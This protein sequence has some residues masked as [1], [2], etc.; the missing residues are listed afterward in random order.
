MNR[1]IT[2]F[3]RIVAAAP[4]LAFVLVATPLSAVKNRAPIRSPG[5]RFALPALFLGILLAAIPVAATAQPIGDCWECVASPFPLAFGNTVCRA[6]SWM[7][8][9][10]CAQIGTEDHHHCVS[11]GDFCLVRWDAADAVAAAGPGDDQ[12]TA[13]GYVAIQGE[14]WVLRQCGGDA[15]FPVR[16][17]SP[18]EDVNRLG[19][20]A[21][22]ATDAEH[23]ADNPLVAREAPASS[24]LGSAA[25]SVS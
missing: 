23:S 22:R 12:P 8:L 4:I 9:S 3:L 20:T 15:D 13:I 5:P 7:G 25:L 17:R 2:K 18:D 14:M 10:N 1:G 21:T 11:Y 24:G 6:G 19:L 16:Q